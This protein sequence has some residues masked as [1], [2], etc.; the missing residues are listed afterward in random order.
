VYGDTPRELGAYLHGIVTGSHA[1][2]D[3]VAAAWIAHRPRGS[4]AAD[5]TFDSV[6]DHA[7]RVVDALWPPSTQGEHDSGR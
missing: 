7:A 4:W 6:C 3:A 5:A 1:S 2:D